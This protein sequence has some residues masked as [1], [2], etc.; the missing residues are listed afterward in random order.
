MKLGILY[1][2]TGPYA[3]FWEDFY[4]SSERFFLSKEDVDKEYFVFT[5]A[6][7]IYEESNPRV[8]K[9]YHQKQPWPYDTLMRYHIFLEKSELYSDMD[10]LFFLNANALFVE[11]IYKEDVLPNKANGKEIT[12]VKYY[13]DTITKNPNETN[14][15]ST[16]F[17]PWKE[18]GV[19]YVA[20]GMNGGFKDSFL[21][22][23]KEISD[24]IDADLKKGIVA[25]SHDQ[26][27]LNN[28]IYRHDNWRLLGKEYDY[29][30]ELKLPFKPKV[31]YRDKSKYFNDVEYKYGKKYAMKRKAKLWIRRVIKWEKI[32]KYFT[33]NNK[34]HP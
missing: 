19:L 10:Y 25:K 14:P 23:A 3:A 33:K 24:R 17:V 1:I 32:K 30:E 29:A 26:S 7:S 28:Y 21:E 2:C 27:H 18:G 5:D 16:A 31:I 8:H 4:K 13:A 11:D 22:M 20:G 34:L 12:V 15:E 9:L 6:E